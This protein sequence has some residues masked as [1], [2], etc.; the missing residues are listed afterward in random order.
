M[1]TLCS[2]FLYYVQ[3][4]YLR[5]KPKMF[6]LD[7]LRYAW[8]FFFSFHFRDITWI[9]TSAFKIRAMESLYHCG[10]RYLEHFRLKSLRKNV[11]KRV[12][13]WPTSIIIS[14]QTWS[15]LSFIIWFSIGQAG[16]NFDAFCS[17]LRKRVRTE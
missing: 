11:N 7:D 5:S 6:E 10:T 2:I 12:P 13:S 17:C 15:S 8:W 3:L 16:K 1:L 9:I 14:N 4:W